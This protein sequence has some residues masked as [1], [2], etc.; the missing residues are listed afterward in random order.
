MAKEK[1][2]RTKPHVNIGTIGH[3]DHG[4]T[5]STSSTPATARTLPATRHRG[6]G[7]TRPISTNTAFRPRAAHSTARYSTVMAAAPSYTALPVPTWLQ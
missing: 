7:L 3:V 5:T 6:C 2:N 4:K 1:F